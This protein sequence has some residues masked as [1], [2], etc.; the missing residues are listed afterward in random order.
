MPYPFSATE[1]FGRATRQG[2][3]ASTAVE[4]PGQKVAGRVISLLFD[5]LRQ[6]AGSGE[7][8]SGWRVEVVTIPLQR[9]S[10]RRIRLTMRGLLTVVKKGQARIALDCDSRRVVVEVN[11]RMEL[12]LPDGSLPNMQRPLDLSVVVPRST[13]PRTELRVLIFMEVNAGSPDAQAEV[14]V[15]S[16]DIEAI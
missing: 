13:H 3:D 10:R 14:A 1:V 15:D 12:P 4:L 5:A 7:Q 11:G 6:Q 8:L 9:A 2:T 16:L